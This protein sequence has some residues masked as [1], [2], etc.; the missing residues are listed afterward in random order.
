MDELNKKFDIQ[1]RCSLF[2]GKKNFKINLK[3]NKEY[4]QEQDCVFKKYV[5]K[6]NKEE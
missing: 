1:I 4:T 6:T 2:G 3:Y 5:P